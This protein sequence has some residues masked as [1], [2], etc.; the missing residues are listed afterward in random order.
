MFRGIDPPGFLF[1]FVIGNAYTQRNAAESRR[2]KD[3]EKNFGA[4]QKTE[5]TEQSRSFPSHGRASCR[6][7]VQAGNTGLDYV[8]SLL[9]QRPLLDRG[10]HPTHAGFSGGGRLLRGGG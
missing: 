8:S 2:I 10:Q 3:F 7:R 5:T 4:Q 1:C 9:P 6:L